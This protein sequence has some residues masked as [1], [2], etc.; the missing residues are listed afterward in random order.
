[1]VFK[2]IHSKLQ[3]IAA[4]SEEDS[5]MRVIPRKKVNASFFGNIPRNEV[6]R[7]NTEVIKSTNAIQ[8]S[9]FN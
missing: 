5:F 2:D 6:L 4:V 1:M 8:L 9:L 7:T 3:A